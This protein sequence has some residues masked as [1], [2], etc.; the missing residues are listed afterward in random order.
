MVSKH[1]DAET[2]FLTATQMLA[3]YG[4]RDFS[5][6]D[7]IQIVLDRID[8]LNGC[9]NAYC[10]VDG[11]RALSEA[12]ASA[13]RYHSGTAEG[14][15][16]G[17]P[18]AIKDV[19][20]TRGWPTL[21]GSRAVDPVGPW[22]EDSPA[23]ARLRGQGAILIGKT[24][25]PELGWKGVTDSPLTGITRN[26][27]DPS[28][29]PGG[30]SGGTA[31]AVSLAMAAIGLG[32]DGGG[33]IRIPSGFS[34]LVGIKPTFGRVSYYPPS[35]FGTLAHAGPI[36]RTVADCALALDVL[37][38]PEPRDWQALPKVRESFSSSLRRGIAGLRVAF[39]QD[40]GYV[41]VDPEVAAAVAQAV[42]V[43]EGLGAVVDQVDPGFADPISDFNILWF[44]GAARALGA[45]DRRFGVD[46]GLIEIAEIGSRYSAV[47]YLRANERR[48]QLGVHL[49]IFHA[50]YDLLL[51]PTLPIRAF[52]AGIEVPPDW[53][54]SRWTSWTP[55]SYPF[56]LT[57]QPALSV[58]CGFTSDGLP[59][60][61]QIIG[62]R[63]AD[64]LVLQAAHAYQTAHPLTQH[65]PSEECL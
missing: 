32:T 42:G 50:T 37:S 6:V 49:G 15:L 23:V 45:L 52:E 38:V 5:P 30:S 40:L 55:F 41:E 63:H 34:G 46:P 60:G 43:F 28:R 7:V 21:K 22:N 48:A 2:A 24:A 12:R 27:W 53:P 11:E 4:N 44:A 14:L 62:A 33:S 9:V 10:I 19:F 31:A 58:P 26:P 20:L 56:N 64:A 36:A 1:T 3:G 8:R 16:D 29:T 13:A 47:E 61:L 65:R 35:P 39:S 59:I 18:V 25:T 51:T 17:V 54:Q 57:Q